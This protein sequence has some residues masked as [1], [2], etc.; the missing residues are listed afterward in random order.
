MSSTA[1]NSRASFCSRT[2]RLSP[3]RSAGRRLRRELKRPSEGC[4]LKTRIHIF[5]KGR[6][7]LSST[8]S[9]SGRTGRQNQSTPR[10]EQP[11]D[12]SPCFRFLS[13]IDLKERENAFSNYLTKKASSTFPTLDVNS[14]WHLHRKSWTTTTFL[15]VRRAM[16][17]FDNLEMFR[18]MPRRR[19]PTIPRPNARSTPRTPTNSSNSNHLYITVSA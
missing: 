17:L 4:F 5:S 14:R 6:R 8:I 10:S 3:S 13:P 9:S 16:K 7:N 11:R 18:Q 19:R 2:T 1:T 15:P 12:S